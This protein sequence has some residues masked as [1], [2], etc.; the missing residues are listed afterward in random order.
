MPQYG[1]PSG[2][3]FSSSDHSYNR[4]S[5]TAQDADEFLISFLRYDSQWASYIRE[6]KIRKKAFADLDVYG[7][8]KFEYS[9]GGWLIELRRFDAIAILMPWNKTVFDCQISRLE[10]QTGQI[11][12]PR[13]CTTEADTYIP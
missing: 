6:N 1:V 2:H 10:R 13:C 5:L 3:A 11:E 9:L 8:F 7:P 12:V 4:R